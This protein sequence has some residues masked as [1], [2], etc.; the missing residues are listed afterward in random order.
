MFWVSQ[1]PE[2][3]SNLNY[4]MILQFYK[5]YYILKNKNNKLIFL[6]IPFFPDSFPY[7]HSACNLDQDLHVPSLE[8]T[9]LTQC[10]FFPILQVLYSFSFFCLNFQK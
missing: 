3:P 6:L 8:N 1:P 2:V 5:Y 4:F 7:N 10:Q 9:H